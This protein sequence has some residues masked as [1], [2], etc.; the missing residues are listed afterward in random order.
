MELVGLA[1]AGGDLWKDRPIP[2]TVSQA[3]ISAVPMM[4]EV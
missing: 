1:D 3:V 4:S 2:W